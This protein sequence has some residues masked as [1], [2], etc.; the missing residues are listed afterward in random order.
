[1]LVAGEY[2]KSALRGVAVIDKSLKGLDRTA[3]KLGVA[4]L[5]ISATSLGYKYA[6]GDGIT[7]SQAFDFAVAGVLT[8]VTVTNPALLIGFGLYGIL[9]AAGAFDGV[10][11]SLGGDTI[12]L[13]RE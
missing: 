11:E 4:G 13:K 8:V 2:S 6:Y 1:M 12:I 9:D 7:A 10:K 5:L 3:R